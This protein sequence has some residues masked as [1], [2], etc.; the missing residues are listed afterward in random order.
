M[1]DL[2]FIDC[3][4]WQWALFQYQVYDWLKSSPTLQKKSRFGFNLIKNRLR[5]GSDKKV[6]SI[7]Y[8][9]LHILSIKYI[10]GPRIN[11]RINIVKQ[12][13]FC[14]D[15]AKFGEVKERK[16]IREPEVYHAYI[17][18]TLPSGANPS[19]HWNKY[20]ELWVMVF[21]GWEGVIY[22]ATAR[23]SILQKTWNNCQTAL[24]YNDIMIWSEPDAVYIYISP[25]Q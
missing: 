14:L 25:Y 13:P 1:D 6:Y 21:H 22:I 4:L 17:Y 7:D 8:S 24:F 16:G 23:N 15:L 9:S 2:K 20:L 18:F 11:F 5:L 3:L 10:F 19:V 12:S